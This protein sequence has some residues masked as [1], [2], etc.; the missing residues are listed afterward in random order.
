MRSLI[1]LLAVLSD[2]APLRLAQ[3]R[4]DVVELNHFYDENGRLVFDQVIFW[5]WCRDSERFQIVA[6]RL[7]KTPTQVPLRDW[8]RG[9]YVTIWMDASR[10]RYV[11]GTAF[12]ESWSQ[13]D[14]ELLERQYKPTGERKELSR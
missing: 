11:R 4:V 14:P 6:W 5:E 7:L 9:G 10:L 3:D 2:G 12:R 8:Q 1:L 13:V